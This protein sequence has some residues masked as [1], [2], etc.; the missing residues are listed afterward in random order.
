MRSVLYS[1]AERQQTTPSRLLEAL[2]VRHL[3][4]FIA[5]EL[6]ESFEPSSELERRMESE[7]T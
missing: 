3:P 5:F 1:E 7:V 4:D 2:L 6:R